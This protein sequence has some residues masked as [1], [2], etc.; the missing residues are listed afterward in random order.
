VAIR[1]PVAGTIQEILVK[2][3][4]HVKKG[5]TLMRL[6]DSDAQLDLKAAKVRLE[7]VRQALASLEEMNKQG[8]ATQTEFRT[9]ETAAALAEVEYQR[10][11][12]QVARAI[13]RSPVDGV[14]EQSNWIPIHQGLMVEGGQTLFLVALAAETQPAEAD[15][16]SSGAGLIQGR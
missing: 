1:S 11:Q 12:L 14:L 7:S 4:Q 13:I 5:D 16:A 8:K 6:D 9:A 2:R 10:A 15:E 3:R